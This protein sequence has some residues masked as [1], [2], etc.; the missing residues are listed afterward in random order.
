M[1]F[2]IFDEKI[3]TRAVSCKGMTMVSPLI[4]LLFASR[5]IELLPSKKVCM[6]I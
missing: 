5:K 1:P 6:D 2:F 4:L 3:R